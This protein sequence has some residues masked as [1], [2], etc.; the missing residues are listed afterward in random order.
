MIAE[1]PAVGGRAHP[2]PGLGAGGGRHRRGPGLLRISDPVRRRATR[3]QS[4]KA[5]ASTATRSCSPRRSRTFSARGPSRPPPRARRAPRL[6]RSRP[7]PGRTPDRG[8]PV[9]G[10]PPPADPRR[11]ARRPDRPRRAAGP[12][13]RLPGAAASSGLRPRRVH[14]GRGRV[15]RRRGYGGLPRRQRDLRLRALA[16]RARAAVAVHAGRLRVQRH[17]QPGRRARPRRSD[18]QAHLVGRPRA[19]GH[20]QRHALGHLRDAWARGPPR[21]P[22]A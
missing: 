14:I 15:D 10:R 13:G 5:S 21:S 4:P 12:A 2:H 17:R 18:L 3:E 19:R 22:C 11:A 7:S 6:L 8:G 1:D 20:H 9:A 16:R